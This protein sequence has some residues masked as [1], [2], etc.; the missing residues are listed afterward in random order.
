MYNYGVNHDVSELPPSPVFLQP[1]S[2]CRKFTRGYC[3]ATTLMMFW[4]VVFVTRMLWPEIYRTLL[5][6]NRFDVVVWCFCN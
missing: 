6:C 3:I 4:F 2:S 1:V 5:Y